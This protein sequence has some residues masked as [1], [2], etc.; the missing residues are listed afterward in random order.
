MYFKTMGEVLAKII[1]IGILIFYSLKAI[2]SVKNFFKPSETQNKRKE[3]EEIIL[4]GERYASDQVLSYWGISEKSSWKRGRELYVIHQ[5][6]LI[7][8]EKKRKKDEDKRKKELISKY[9]DII[10]NKL[11]NRELAIGM[12]YE[13]LKIWWGGKEDKKITE[14]I[15]KKEITK[16]YFG[17]SKNRLGNEK[18]EFEV[19]LE[20][21]E[22]I[23]WVDLENRR[24][25]RT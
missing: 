11:A 24:N 2:K 10:G 22:V 9:G 8:I 14:A 23:G 3:I 7:N 12:N 20:N 16:L 18:F 1:I 15:N 21:G 13:H 6:N 17:E 25:Q 4:N 19:T 5:Q